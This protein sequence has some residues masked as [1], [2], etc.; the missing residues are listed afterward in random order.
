MSTQA[1]REKLKV[2]P[3][4]LS[5]PYL[6]LLIYGEPGAGKT[7][8]AGTALDDKATSPVLLLDVEGGAVTLRSRKSLD[9]VQVR[10]IKEVENVNNEL[11]NAKDMHYKTVIIDSLTELQKLDMRTV[12]QNEYNRTPEKVDID[13]PSQRAWGK[14]GERVRRIITAYKDLPCH[15]I[16]T[17]LVGSEL[18][19]V[20]GVMNYYPSLPGK[21]RGDVP[22]YFDVVGYLKATSKKV[23]QDTEIVRTLQ[24]A[25]TERVV[26]K[27]RTGV[28]GTLIEA[29]T[30]PDMWSL[31]HASNTPSTNGSKAGEVKAA[32]LKPS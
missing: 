5:V 8:L 22:G 32:D 28:L 14:S 6:N 20:N 2:Q 10:T 13:V 4:E 26:A 31:I 24:V 11:Y 18:D 15:V 9:V 29:P 16:A 7:Y 27:D 17:C 21:L 25:K 1:L 3:P 12:Q 23:G 30:I 19:E